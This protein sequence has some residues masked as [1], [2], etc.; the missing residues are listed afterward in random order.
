M[1]ADHIH[2]VNN[3]KRD[4]TLD[5][6][7]K[8]QPGMDRL[9]AEVGPRVHRMYYAAKAGNWPLAA[10]FSKSVVKQLQLSVESR[11]K[12]DPEMTDYLRDDYAPV[13][14]AIRAQDAAAFETAYAHMVD[15]ANELHGVFGKPYIGWK[16]PAAPP[17]DLDLTAGM[18]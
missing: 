9:M 17:D 18:T 1:S 4:L 14:A 5:E 3:G 8:Q 6:L 16:T 15:R 7:A 2:L 12:Y 10:Y 11:P 13:S